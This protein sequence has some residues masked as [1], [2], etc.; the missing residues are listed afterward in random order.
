MKNALLLLVGIL[1]WKNAAGQVLSVYPTFPTADGEIT[2][3]FDLRQARDTRAAALLNR[4]DDVYLWA[5]AG[6]NPANRSNPEF[7]LSALASFNQPYAPA[8]LSP[9]GNDRWSIRLT[10]RKFLNQT[11]D[12]PSA[13]WVVWSKT[14]LAPPKPKILPLSFTHPPCK[15]FFLLPTVPASRLRPALPWP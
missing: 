1:F 11:A 7:T 6:S 13:G 9:L 10:P 14:G 3:V 8:K 4:S 15:S 2:L 12:K 5:W